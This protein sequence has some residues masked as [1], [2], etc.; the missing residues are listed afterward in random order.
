MTYPNV[1][2]IKEL[3]L[4]QNILTKLGGNPF[5]V[6]SVINGTALDNGSIFIKICIPP[7]VSPKGR[8][9]PE[10]RII[11]INIIRYIWFA[12]CS[13]GLNAEINNPIQIPLKP[14]IIKTKKKENNEPKLYNPKNAVN[15]KISVDWSNIITKLAISLLKIIS[16]L[17]VGVISIR[18]SGPSETIESEVKFIVVPRIII[19]KIKGSA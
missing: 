7:S 3:K 19:G 10:K 16:L 14:I 2:Y 5:N 11:I 6:I 8:I 15:I 1:T 18:G 9:L 4:S 12:L 17:A 13:V